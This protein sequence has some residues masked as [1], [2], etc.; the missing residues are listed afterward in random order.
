MGCTL[1]SSTRKS[2]RKIKTNTPDQR[3]STRKTGQTTDKHLLIIINKNTEFC[4][5][6]EPK[7][8]IIIIVIIIIIIV[9]III[10]I[11][12]IIKI[13]SRI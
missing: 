8:I 9:I 3:R 4:I 11:I 10:I 13:T 12:I 1:N 2:L 7:L 5:H 6:R